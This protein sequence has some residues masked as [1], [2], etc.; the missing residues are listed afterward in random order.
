MSKLTITIADEAPP[1]EDLFLAAVHVLSRELETLLAISGWKRFIFFNPDYRV[2]FGRKVKQRKM[3]PGKE[4][5]VACAARIF[6]APYIRTLPGNGE[7]YWIS[8]AVVTPDDIR[9][10]LEIEVLSRE[11]LLGIRRREHFFFVPRDQ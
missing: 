4:I 5:L 10:F 2:W 3:P 11:K 9:V 8:Y 7:L 6:E 1:R